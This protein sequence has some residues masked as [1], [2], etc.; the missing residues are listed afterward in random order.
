MIGQG[1]SGIKK[2]KSHGLRGKHRHSIL[3]L[4]LIVLNGLLLCGCLVG[5]DYHAPV[6]AMPDKWDSPPT[7]QASV[8]LHQ[9]SQMQAW[10]TRFDDPELN[11]LVK[12][13]LAQNLDLEAAA[14]R[15][16]AARAQL[17]V[18]KGELLPT[19]DSDGSYTRSG[20]GRINWGSNW[21]G[22]LNEAWNVDV[23]GGTRRGIEQAGASLWAAEW[24]R[25]DVLV[26]V[27]GEVATDYI[28]L[29]GNQQAVVIAKEN[30]EVDARNAKVARDKKRLGTGTDLD[31]AQADAEVASTKAALE[32]L[33]AAEQQSIYAISILL[34]MPPTALNDELSPVQK[35]PDPPG[36]I[37]VGL[38]SDLLRR[39]P[40]IRRSERQLAAATAG[41]GVAVAQL[42]PQFTLTG[43]VG[44]QSRQISLQNWDNSFWSFGPGVTWS[45][46][47]ANIIR[48][49][50]DLQN[51]LT[52]QAATAYRQT[53]LNALL[54]VQNV[55][56]AYAHEQHRRAALSDAV[57]WNQLAVE[58]SSKRYQDGQTDFLAVLDAERTLFA[59]QNA[60]VISNQTVGTDAVALYEALGGGW[61]VPSGTQP[62]S[63]K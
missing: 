2:G 48:S 5:P 7:T 3:A 13:A 26:T 25:R 29:R 9:P 54:Q 22:G 37:P 63:T 28:T 16:H 8:I 39:R 32:S 49:Q 41:I 35:V 18:A 61:D 50:I 62:V 43:T 40:D 10:W 4:V 38:P 60:L 31:I 53:V 34:A 44:L 21:V 33:E 15:I 57:K 14:E 46:L 47:D 52:E 24:D 19:V 12:R 42:F 20:G 17:G 30:L 51:A 58:L 59:S 23:F 11:S 45:I 36:D 56:V 6:Q 1:L 27:L 55:L